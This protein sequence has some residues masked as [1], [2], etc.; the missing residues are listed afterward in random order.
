[1][2]FSANTRRLVAATASAVLAISVPSA[3]VDAHPHV[4]VKVQSQVL[5]DAKGQVTGL[6]HT[7]TFD[8][9]Y[10]A[11]AIQG[12][13][14]DG[15]GKLSQAELEPLAKENVASLEEF[16]YF[17]FLKADGKLE[18]RAKPH[19]YR[20]DHAAGILTLHF[21]LP[22]KRAVDPLA[23]KVT[24]SIYDPTHFV[25]FDFDKDNAVMLASTAPP[26]CQA[27][28]EET[29]M[30]EVKL[31]DMGESFYSSLDASSEFG[32]QFA[33]SVSIACDKR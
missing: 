24:F 7:W 33:K 28:F 31:S 5:H 14:S 12:L 16:D 8:E 2:A 20:L 1:M 30:A 22:L 10:S 9:F 11:F 6:R 13:D 27:K 4:W 23:Q 3:P 17:T 15:D 21:T 29:K 26:T 32:A 18:E 25:A 19:D